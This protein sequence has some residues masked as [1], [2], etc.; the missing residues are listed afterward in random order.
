MT[1][2]ISDINK[3]LSKLNQLTKIQKDFL[4][5]AKAYI[6]VDPED[7]NFLKPSYMQHAEQPT[8]LGVPYERTTYSYSVTPLININTYE[9]VRDTKVD[10]PGVNRHLDNEYL[11]LS[12]VPG[13]IHSHLTIPALEKNENSDKLAPTTP[14]SINAKSIITRINDLH[15]NTRT[16][17]IVLGNKSKR[18]NIDDYV[19]FLKKDSNFNE[20]SNIE[21]FTV[22]IQTS[23]EID[24][25]YINAYDAKMELTSEGVD[26]LY[27]LYNNTIAT[28]NPLLI[29]CQQGLDRTGKL[30]FAYELFRN[31][32]VIFKSPTS[33]DVGIKLQEAHER[34]CR[35]R[36]I[37][38]LGNIRD[39]EQAIILGM[40]FKAC[41]LEQEVYVAL[42]NHS[43][44]LNIQKISKHSKL[45]EIISELGK[46][47]DLS[48]KVE[49][50]EDAITD[51]D[52]NTH[53]NFTFFKYFPEI[54]QK[55]R[56]DTTSITLLKTLKKAIQQRI[57][58]E[59]NL[60]TFPQERTEN[61]KEE[62]EDIG[63]GYQ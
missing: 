6:H 9:Y 54:I 61:L 33:I 5:I 30:A 1:R 62:K 58:I 28:K 44:I 22:N 19:N 12:V 45:D 56:S 59:K 21:K 31:Y 24:L 13:A 29:H 15:L 18:E 27:S 53:R 43:N 60:A 7:T 11:Y 25:Y 23:R 38:T 57:D 20:V 55:L 63:F 4:N 46:A 8:M 35:S 34:L 50:L 37:K 42:T 14:G 48:S 52:L 49:I 36:S 26:I 51:A 10:I 16:T 40:N 17:F 41:A 3:D 32:N 47:K 39:F 2:N